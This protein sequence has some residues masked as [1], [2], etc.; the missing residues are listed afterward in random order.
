M[1]SKSPSFLLKS[2]LFFANISVFFVIKLHVGAP[3]RVL[4]VYRDCSSFFSTRPTSP[5]RESIARSKS[6]K[7][8]RLRPACGGISEV[9]GAES[10]AN[11][12]ALTVSFLACERA[13]YRLAASKGRLSAEGLKKRRRRS[14]LPSF[15][16]RGFCTQSRTKKIRSA[17][18]SKR[19][20][21]RRKCAAS[22]PSVRT[23]PVRRRSNPDHAR[24]MCAAFSL[25]R[26]GAAD[27]TIWIRALPG[28]GAA[29][30][31]VSLGRK[32]RSRAGPSRSLAR[33][34]RSARPK[35]VPARVFPL[36]ST[37]RPNFDTEE[38]AQGRPPYIF[39]KAFHTQRAPQHLAP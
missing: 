33:S 1:A 9:R 31:I 11:A 34:A 26:R 16:S 5:Y 14:R 32:R 37:R 2:F 7:R 3:R 17:T 35:D 24:E 10:E 27:S 28:Q 30:R 20:R 13:A 29:S 39:Q 23:A 22:P 18:P 36:F 12:P 38:P 6:P 4:V 8:A 15:S 21:S 19:R 25:L